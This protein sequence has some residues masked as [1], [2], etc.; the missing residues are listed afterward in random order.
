M[1]NDRDYIRMRAT[2]ERELLLERFKERSGIDTDS[3]AFDEALRRAMSF[4][5]LVDEL[6]AEA[7]ESAK[8]RTEY[9]EI[10]VRTRL[11]RR[12]R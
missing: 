5:E 4:S 9:H 10:E 3:K 6:R 2:T 12:D 8:Y 1:A 7:R 11:K